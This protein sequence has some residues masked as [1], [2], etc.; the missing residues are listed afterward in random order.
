MF[1]NHS[2]TSGPKTLFGYWTVLSVALMMV[3]YYRVLCWY[4]RMVLSTDQQGRWG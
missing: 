4:E 3:L 2:N 1:K